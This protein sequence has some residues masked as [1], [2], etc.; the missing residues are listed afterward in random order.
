L[1]HGGVGIL[2]GHL[3]AKA[4]LG[5]KIVEKLGCWV[6]DGVRDES[7]SPV[8]R[9]QSITGMITCVMVPLAEGVVHD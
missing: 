7:G 1:V 6:N 5:G 2:L 9:S 8:N 4:S 3:C